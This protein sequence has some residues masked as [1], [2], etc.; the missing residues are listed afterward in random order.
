MASII[1]QILDFISSYI[2]QF[3]YLGIGIGM[4]IESACIPLPSEIVLPIGGFMVA[5]GRITMLGANIAVAIG[6][7][8]GSLLAY[9]VGRYGG[10]SLILNYGKYFFVPQKKFLAVEKAFNKYGSTAVFF[11]RLLPIVRTFISLPAGM[12]KMNLGKFILYSLSGMLPWNFA[13]IFLGFWFRND[14]ER[15]IHPLFQKFEYVV[16][17]ILVLGGAAFVIRKVKFKKAYND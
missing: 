1:S 8:V 12:A 17:A 5:D 9:F 6:S 3:G 16:L 7:I 10:R 14:Y 2:N 15:V 4:L 11:G 13:L